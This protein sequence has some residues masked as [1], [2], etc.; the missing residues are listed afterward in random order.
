VREKEIQPLLEEKMKII[1]KYLV[2]VGADQR[3]AEDIVQETIYKFCLNIETIDPSKASSWLFRVAVN[4][5]FDICRRR[6][7]HTF[8]SFDEAVLKDGSLLPEEFVLSKENEQEI[9]HVMNQ[10]KPI[11][12]NL[13]VL[14]YSMGLSYEEIADSLDIKMGTL[15]TYLFR[16]RE[17]FKLIYGREFQND[18]PKRR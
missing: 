4:Q 6:K 17:N 15:K 10:M 7:K 1:Y 3:D 5:Y 18:K 2:K 14:K 9:E 8:T 12:K 16:A 11:Y 13:L